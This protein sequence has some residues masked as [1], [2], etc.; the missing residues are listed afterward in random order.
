MFTSTAPHGSRA[1]FRWVKAPTSEDLTQ[2]THTIAQRIARYLERQGLLVRDAD[3]SYLTA[4]AVDSK[5]A[6][7]L[8]FGTDIVDVGDFVTSTATLLCTPDEPEV[9]DCPHGT[10]STSEFSAAVEVT[11]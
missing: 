3:N 9:G 5:G 7:Q 4:D 11:H 1:R 2:L 8:E 10:S 6:F